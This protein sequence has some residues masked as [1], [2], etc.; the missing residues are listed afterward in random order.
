MLVQAQLCLQILFFNFKQIYMQLVKYGSDY[1]ITEEREFP[2]ITKELEKG[3]Y[4]LN[5]YMTISGSYFQLDRIEDLTLP[6]KLYG[7]FKIV[8]RVLKAFQNSI[9]NVALCLAGIKGAGKTITAKLLCV[10]SGLPVIIINRSY[11]G[12]AFQEFINSPLLNNCVIF[13]DE[14]EKLF[15]TKHNKDDATKDDTTMLQVLDGTRTNRKLFVLTSNDNV[16][17]ELFVNRLGRVKYREIFGYLSAEV[18]EAIG[19]D[20]LKNQDLLPS[21]MTFR[22]VFKKVTYDIL[23]GIINDMNL[24]NEDAF[25]VSEYMNIQFEPYYMDVQ[26]KCLNN[27]YTFKTKH[28]DVD[29]R[30]SDIHFDIYGQFKYFRFTDHEG[31]IPLLDSLGKHDFYDDDRYFVFDIEKENMKE[32]FGGMFWEYLQKDEETGEEIKLRIIFTEQDYIIEN[33]RFHLF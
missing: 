22:K 1:R 8:P 17:G 26:I 3:T 23:V 12:A 9:T 30:R 25:T 16:L 15:S 18:V 2:V 31:T 21:L 5:E 4:Q 13:I 28:L 29:P 20:E 11:Q 33:K 6:P 32:G 19:K 14:F 24:F 10:M 27:K 7:N